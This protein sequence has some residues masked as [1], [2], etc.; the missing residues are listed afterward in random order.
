MTTT[1]NTKNAKGVPSSRLPFFFF[2]P[3]VSFAV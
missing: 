3:F 2:V 1:K